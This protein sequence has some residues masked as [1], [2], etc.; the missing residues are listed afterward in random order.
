[1][2]DRYDFL[3]KNGIKEVELNGTIHKGYRLRT[4]KLRGQIAQGL[5]L[6]FSFFTEKLP[7]EVGTDITELLGVVKWEPPIKESL[8][9]MM[10]KGN[11]PYFIP[12]TDEERIQNLDLASLNG[13]YWNAFEKIDGTSAT[14]FK[15]QGEVGICSRNFEQK[16]EGS[17]V[18]T[19]VFNKYDL[20]NIIPEGIAIQ[21]EIAGPGIQKNRQGFK[22]LTMCLFN[23]FDINK[24][25][26]IDWYKMGMFYEIPQVPFFYYYLYDEEIPD[27]ETWLTLATN[28]G[29]NSEG[30]V[31]SRYDTDLPFGKESFKVI[32]NEYLVKNQ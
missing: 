17:N 28:S 2:E 18:Y 22:E 10:P 4:M 5:A 15:W 29:K 25:C 20:G 14:Y 16:L 9:Q 7:T 21:A 19:R 11:F 12:K 31:F 1:M 27:I 23:V 32:N 26:Y 3:S 6:P 30:I 13:K 24:Q 8:G